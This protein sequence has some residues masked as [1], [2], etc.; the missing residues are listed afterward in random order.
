M[1]VFVKTIDIYVWILLAQSCCFH[2]SVT[3][4][5]F[6][7]DHPRVFVFEMSLKK[8]DIWTWPRRHRVSRASSST[9]NVFTLGLERLV[10]LVWGKWSDS[11]QEDQVILI[12]IVVALK[13]VARNEACAFFTMCDLDSVGFGLGFV[14]SFVHWVYDFNPIRLQV[15][16]SHSRKTAGLP[17]LQGI[18]SRR[19]ATSS[20]QMRILH[21]KLFS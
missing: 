6:C 16:V 15:F 13:T 4:N 14:A 19:E 8:S 10:L 21:S 12:C 1:Q 20:K 5:N 9:F 2:N 3:Q 18:P 11:P 17:R 7:G